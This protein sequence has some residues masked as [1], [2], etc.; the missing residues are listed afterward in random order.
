MKV[1][2][3]LL[4]N[5]QTNCYIVSDDDHHCFIV[6]PGDN[7]KKVIKFLND[8]ELILDAIL[9]THGHLII[10]MNIVIVLFIFIKK[11]LHYCMMQKQTFQFLK[12]H[13]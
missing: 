11:I 2:T 12:Y 6:D 3:L 9:L 10:Y 13:L 1:K 4:G 7:G 5:M 8:N